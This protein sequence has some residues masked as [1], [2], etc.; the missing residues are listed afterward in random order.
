[1]VNTHEKM[2]KVTL[3]AFKSKLPQ[4][5]TLHLLGWLDPK[6]QMGT[7]VGENL[8]KAKPLYTVERM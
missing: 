8:E 3:G 2:L 7:S 6:R 1:M 4:D 5:S